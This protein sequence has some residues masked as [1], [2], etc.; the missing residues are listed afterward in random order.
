MLPTLYTLSSDL[1][2]RNPDPFASGGYGDV[3]R[4]TLGDTKVCIKRVRAYTRDGPEK[5]IKVRYRCHCLPCSPSLTKPVDLLQGGGDVETFE[6]PEYRTPTWRHYRS[7]P[8]HLGV[9][10][11]R[12][13]TGLHPDEPRCRPTWTCKCAYRC[14]YPMLTPIVSC[15][16]SLRV[17]ATS[18]P[19]IWFMGTSRGCVVALNLVLSPR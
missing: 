9:G 12:G 1:L 3:Y 11:Q 7:I 6:T 14:V 17:S 15:P 19:E 4:G 5:A 8:A 16:T 2:A 13:P 10:V 18:T